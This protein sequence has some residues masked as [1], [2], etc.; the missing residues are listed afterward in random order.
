M[1]AEIWWF[2]ADIL[3]Q[4]L[5]FPSGADFF[6]VAAYIPII[7]ALATRSSSLPKSLSLYQQISIWILG[8]VYTGI[9]GF[10][11][12]RPAVANFVSDTMLGGFVSVFYPLADI[13]LFA[14]SLRTLFSYRQGLYGRAWTWI[15]AGFALFAVSD[16]LFGYTV[17]AGLYYPEGEL[18]LIST[19]G[20]DVTYSASYFLCLVGVA[21]VQTL[22]VGYRQL[23]GTVPI[24]DILPN[25]H[26]FLLTKDDCTITM[27]SANYA[28]I[29]PLDIQDIKGKTIAEA[30]GTLPGDA[31]VLIKDIKTVKTING[32]PLNV[33]TRYGVQ[34]ALV[35]G[36]SV[37]GPEGK[38]FGGM[39]LLL[40]IFSE[41]YALD[42]ILT[43]YEKWVV[44]IL[45]SKTGLKEREELEIKRFLSNYYTGYLTAL[46][47]RVLVEGGGIMVDAFLA[48]L[49]TVAQRQGWRV[50]FMT[51]PFLD[52]G[53]L[54][55]AQTRECL[56][57]LLN[58]AKNFTAR[59]IDPVTTEMIVDGIRAKYSD[60]ILKNVSYYETAKETHP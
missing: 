26:V 9:T 11:V 32:R 24:L 46:Y 2:T 45:L 58:T 13:T 56:P 15:S 4:E 16:L 44:R 36:M 59:V 47:N 42:E 8:L 54:T 25:A 40:W 50:D 34:Q 39:A 23:E 18:N 38:D 19:V 22:Q 35:S 53:T 33:K 41:D 52:I 1:I 3:L 10:F 43:D 51:D 6:W 48:E 14:L 7:A 28:Q 17:N 27:V 57:A 49:R 29:F 60:M 31:D 21:Q 55:L 12:L 37:E 30:L 5:P 20:V